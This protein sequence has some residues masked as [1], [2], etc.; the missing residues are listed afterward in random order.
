MVKAAGFKKGVT[1]Y[2]ICGNAQ[3][4]IRRCLRSCS[5]ADQIIVVFANSTDD[6]KSIVSHDFP[7]AVQLST[8]DEYNRH[9]AKWRNLGLSKVKYQWLLYVDTDEI[10]TEPLRIEISKIINSK[11]NYLAYVIPR[12]NHYLGHRV[13]YGGS[14]PDYVKRLYFSSKFRGYQ[15][16]LH[17]EPQYDGEFGYLTNDLLHF[18]HKDLSSML[19]KSIVW[20]DSEANL[21]FQNNHPP[22]YWWRFPRMMLTK[23]WERFIKES[24]WKDGIIG[25]IS[26]IF[27]VFNTYMIYA[28]LYE[29]QQ[30]SKKLN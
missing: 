4:D 12:A 19:Q 7:S 17:E 21:L 1:V 18:T 5:W 13:R 14:Y 23:F 8:F 15:G 6:S 2:V 27:E 22:V 3:T 10:V 29:L 30:N 24:I 28:R 16:L 25:L 26:V 9:F 20:S 11:P